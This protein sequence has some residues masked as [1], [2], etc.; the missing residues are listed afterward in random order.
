MA[1][2]PFTYLPF[3]LEL[4]TNGLGPEV[5]RNVKKL[6]RVHRAFLS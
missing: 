3:K 2:T 5:Y 1:F 4:S 6:F